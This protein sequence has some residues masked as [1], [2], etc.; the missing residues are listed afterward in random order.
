MSW[1]DLFWFPAEGLTC[2]TGWTVVPSRQR[3]ISPCKRPPYWHFRV[4]ATEDSPAQRRVHAGAPEA[5]QH[6]TVTQIE[7]FLPP[8]R[9]SAD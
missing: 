1:G 8:K 5:N 7:R 6:L 3:L 4:D 2:K 9:S